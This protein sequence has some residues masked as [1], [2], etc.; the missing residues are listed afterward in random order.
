MNER[1]LKKSTPPV[2]V[3]GGKLNPPVNEV[4]P[5]QRLS[6]SVNDWRTSESCETGRLKHGLSWAPRFPNFN[7]EW[8]L[9]I[10]HGVTQAELS[11]QYNQINKDSKHYV[12]PSELSDQHNKIDKD[13]KHYV[14]P[15]S[16]SSIT[17]L[18]TL[19]TSSISHDHKIR[20]SQFVAKRPKCSSCLPV[21]E[22]EK[23]TICKWKCSERER[24]RVNIYLAANYPLVNPLRIINVEIVKHL[25]SLFL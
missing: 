10:L 3:R 13:S 18:A 22:L 1:K 8:K 7:M 24:E 17:K 16:L 23:K 5:L 25:E 6:V 9:D 4:R 12:L 14:L 2:V 15:S 20:V 19:T 21:T 11:D